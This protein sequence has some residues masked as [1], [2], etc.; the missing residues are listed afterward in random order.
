MVVRPAPEVLYDNLEKFFPNA[1][2]DQPVVDITP[3]ASP[4]N[5]KQV[6]K[7]P[8][9]IQKT[10]ISSTSDE[11]GFGKLSKPHR[12][13]TIRAVARE[14]S[15]ARKRESIRRT[16]N[17][18][19]NLVRRQ[20]TKMWGKKVV[21]VKPNQTQYLSK[22]RSQKGE[23]K[24]FS[25]IRGELIG[26]G[27]FGNVYLA[28]NVTTGEMIAVKQVLAP[29]RVSENAKVPEVIEA[30][31]SEVE[32]LKDLDHLNIVQY[33][34]FEKT[35]KEYNLF[36]EYVAGGSVAS[37]LRLYGKFEEPLIR[38]L[39]LQVLKGLSY[40]H[41]KGILHRDMKADNILLDL[42][43]VCK[44]SDF[45][46][47][48]KSND[49][50]ANDAAM[51]MQGTIFW[52]APEVVD[53]REGYSA[54]VDI[55]SLGCVVLE[56]FAGRRPWSNLEAITAMFKIG[57]AKAAPPIPED[58]LPSVS[59]EGRN[60]LDSCFAIDASK[61]PT[62][63][64]LCNDRFCE[65]EPNFSFSSTRLAQLIKTNEKKITV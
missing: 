7:D 3:P 58:I 46:I 24:Q 37:C 43:G 56:M 65:V 39:T 22:L 10:V 28:L 51:S 38:F 49:I 26:K 57:K 60:F 50:Y 52:M 6:K 4:M 61:R 14:A 20:S 32:T 47:S 5:D 23:I 9:R 25:W 29:E 54:K 1:N 12:V 35:E 34:G 53:S 44:I 17:Q 8:S 2:L 63:Q 33:L 27:T 64:E 21:E 42:D 55:W 16:I 11:E 36:L 45:G 15:E 41:T 48:K 62:A 40:L 18:N 19:T 31:R 13:K 30:L 59:M